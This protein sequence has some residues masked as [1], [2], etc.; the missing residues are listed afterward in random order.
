MRA[1]SLDRR[2]T[3]LRRSLSRNAFGE[4][5]VEYNA[6][7]TVWAQK[8]DV[9]GREYFTAQR[10]LAVGTTRFRIRYRNDLSVTDRISYNEH[11]YDIKQLTELGRHEGL[12]IV[13]ER[14]DA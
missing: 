13:A 7:D 4:E 6:F 10:D 8:L 14:H 5:E 1:G 11:V 3:L 12:D 2:V 9:T